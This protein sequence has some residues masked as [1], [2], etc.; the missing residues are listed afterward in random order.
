MAWPACLQGELSEL[1]LLCTNNTAPG[2]RLPPVTEQQ[3][4]QHNDGQQLG[5][6]EEGCSADCLAALQQ[7]S[8][9][10]PYPNLCAGQW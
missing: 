1:M 10:S 5:A 7:A 8:C 3:Q 9:T 2:Q 4:Q 6:E